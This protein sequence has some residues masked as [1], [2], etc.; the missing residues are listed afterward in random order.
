MTGTCHRPRTTTVARRDQ[1]HLP[2]SREVLTP[3]HGRR[4]NGA[5]VRWPLAAPLPAQ[6][7]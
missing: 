4:E 3:T 1:A 2:D 7:R 6:H 5:T